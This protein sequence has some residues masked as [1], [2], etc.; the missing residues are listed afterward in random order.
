[1]EDAIKEYG[2]LDTTTYE[3]VD[4]AADIILKSMLVYGAM[5]NHVE[6]TSG[7]FGRPEA[8][9][10]EMS[11]LHNMLKLKKSIIDKRTAV[12]QT[13]DDDGLG[14]YEEARRIEQDTSNG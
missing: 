8:K 2:D 9:F 12:V 4:K 11:A 13:E 10:N 6:I 5:R 7:K 3:G 14:S 1:M